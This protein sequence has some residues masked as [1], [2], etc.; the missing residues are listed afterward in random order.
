[1]IWL[2]TDLCLPCG[3]AMHAK[4]SIWR[5][6]LHLRLG[7]LGKSA[8]DK[9][10][11]SGLVNL[12]C[13]NGNTPPFCETCVVCKPVVIDIRKTCDTPSLDVDFHTLGIDLNGPM[14]VPSLGGGCYSIVVVYFQTCYILHNVLRH[15]RE[16]R[17]SLSASIS[18]FGILDTLFTALVSTM[19]LCF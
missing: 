1:L 6:L 16:T 3:T 10:Q 2:D 18:R 19:I 15:E 13:G 9:L 7:H 17:G 12:Q 4:A 5:Q 8:M 14:S 11:R